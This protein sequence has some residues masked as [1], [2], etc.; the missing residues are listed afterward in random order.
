MEQIICQYILSNYKGGTMIHHCVSECYFL[1]WDLTKN[2]FI[3]RNA[4]FFAFIF[5][6]T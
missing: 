5:Q 3:L 2:V 1:A 6:H 4:L